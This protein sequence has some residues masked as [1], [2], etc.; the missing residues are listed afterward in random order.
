MRI[1]HITMQTKQA[2][3][4]KSNLDC[5]CPQLYYKQYKMNLN[6]PSNV[7]LLRC[8]LGNVEHKKSNTLHKNLEEF[9]WFIILIMCPSTNSVCLYHYAYMIYVI[10]WKLHYTAHN[11]HL[12]VGVLLHSTIGILYGFVR[13][14]FPQLNY[15][16]WTVW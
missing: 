3:L 1:L 12:N 10:P 11:L 6:N 2:K 7:C 5:C 8:D 15:I 16:V 9:Q 13:C 14:L 4:Y